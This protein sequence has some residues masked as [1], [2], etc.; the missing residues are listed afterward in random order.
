MA[1]VSS[2]TV[3]LLSNNYLLYHYQALAAKARAHVM[4]DNDDDNR[5]KDTAATSPVICP[6]GSELTDSGNCKKT[7]QDKHPENPITTINN[8]NMEANDKPTHNSHSRP[9]SGSSPFDDNPI[10][11]ITTDTHKKIISNKDSNDDNND[12]KDA[13]TNG[14]SNAHANKKSDLGSPFFSPFDD[15]VNPIT[16]NGK[17]KKGNNDDDNRAKDT[18]ATSPVICPNGSE[19]TES[20]N[21]KKTIQ[22][23][24][25]EN[26]IT[27]IPDKSD[28]SNDK[29]KHITIQQ[30]INCKEGKHFDFILDKCV[31]DTTPVENQQ[32]T[33]RADTE[34]IPQQGTTTENPQAVHEKGVD[35][36][37]GS[38]NNLGLNHDIKTGLCVTNEKTI[39]VPSQLI[40]V[41][42][43]LPKQ[44]DNT[45][46]G[47]SGERITTTVTTG[48]NKNNSATDTQSPP[49]CPKDSKLV[50]EK[51]E[52]QLHP[53]DDC[54]FNPSL[55]KCKSINGQCPPGFFLNDDENCVP[56]KK[57]PKGFEHHSDDE[58]GTC[59]PVKVK[60]DCTKNPKDSS[61]LQQQQE[62]LKTLPCTKDS[63]LVNGKCQY[64]GIQQPENVIVVK[65]QVDTDTVTKNFISKNIISPSLSS[66]G[67]QQQQPTFLLLL[68]T[69]QLCQIAGDTKCVAKQNQFKTLNLLTKFDETGKSWTITG[70]ADNVAAG[71][72]TQRNVQVIAHFYD[73][74]GNNVGGVQEV[75][76]NPT[77]IKS[78]QV[79]AFNIKASTSTMKGTPSFLRLEYQS[80]TT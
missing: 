67:K 20:G 17:H 37:I 80:A 42:Q 50:N 15:N 5:A 19:L 10:T 1:V 54:L 57:C 51:C 71:A 21:C 24:H 18:A 30:D 63:K 44:N 77:V 56:D 3:N 69:A 16:T 28:N 43:P 11:T 39:T 61:C 29:H 41:Q 66:Q 12:D 8:D 22:D 27:I 55:K 34:S 49:S 40:T 79:G 65:T 36:V 32:Q 64:V 73:S 13:T 75:A 48:D 68:D 7:I 9:D 26:P 53:D 74:K 58:T 70:Q 14:D 62:P 47:G 60:V 45:G 6:N 72:K 46:G 59:H 78:L 25:P 2:P 38:C 31:K 23:K 52:T 33:R 76:V 35:R 4:N